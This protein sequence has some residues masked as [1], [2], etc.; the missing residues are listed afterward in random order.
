MY[1]FTDSNCVTAPGGAGR[2]E[3]EER[4]VCVL[5]DGEVLWD[6]GEE[7]CGRM[8]K[9]EGGDGTTEGECI[10]GGECEDPDHILESIEVFFFFSFLF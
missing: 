5:N 7:E 2:E 4:D 3:C 8:G 6:V 9:C 1:C 10:G